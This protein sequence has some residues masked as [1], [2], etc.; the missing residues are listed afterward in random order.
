MQKYS[1]TVPPL[2]LP[3]QDR[4]SE[5]RLSTSGQTDATL[6]RCQTPVA[7]ITAAQL[8][9]HVRNLPRHTVYETSEEYSRSD[10]R[11]KQ[12]TAKKMHVTSH[13]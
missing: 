9:V 12:L 3:L 13:K 8:T 2:L 10:F 11:E 5:E 6:L 7:F 1:R 4:I